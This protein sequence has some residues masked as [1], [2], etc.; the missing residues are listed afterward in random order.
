MAF[1]L[2][3]VHSFSGVTEGGVL[4]ASLLLKNTLSLSP[5]LTS[6]VMNAVCYFIGFKILGKT[7][8]VYSGIGALSFSVSYGLLEKTEPLLDLSPTLS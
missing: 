7:F 5:A 3:E 6:F 1:G 4:G 2:Y 8:L